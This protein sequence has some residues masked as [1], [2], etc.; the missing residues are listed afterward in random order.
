MQYTDSGL[1]QFTESVAFFGAKGTGGKS[2]ISEV[3]F[4]LERGI[5]SLEESGFPDI[6]EAAAL[7]R[8]QSSILI[9]IGITDMN[10]H[11]IRCLQARYMIDG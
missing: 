4:L 11:A 1:R 2:R 7:I 6:L 10:K 5:W 9:G 3:D 8:R